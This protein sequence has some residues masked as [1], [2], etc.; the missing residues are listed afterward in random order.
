M[1]SPGTDENISAVPARY[2]C[3]PGHYLSVEEL[4]RCHLCL[5]ERQSMHFNVQNSFQSKYKNVLDRMRKLA[6]NRRG[7]KLVRKT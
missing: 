3:D 5:T 7:I 6:K 2:W 1:F 4:S